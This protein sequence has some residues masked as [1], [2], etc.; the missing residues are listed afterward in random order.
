MVKEQLKDLMRQ[1][2]PFRFVR[3]RDPDGTE[4][5]SIEKQVEG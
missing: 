5:I 2:I 1:T 4:N 3:T